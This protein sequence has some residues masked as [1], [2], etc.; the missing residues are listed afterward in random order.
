MRLGLERAP[1]RFRIRTILNQ[2]RDDVTMP[3][4]A[5]QHRPM[6][7]KPPE[8]VKR[9]HDRN[10]AAPAARG[11]DSVWRKYSA[12]YRVNNPVCRRHMELFKLAVPVGQVDHIE[13]HEG[14]EDPKFWDKKNHQPLCSVCGAIKSGLERHGERFTQDRPYPDASHGDR[15]PRGG[16]HP[17]SSRTPSLQPVG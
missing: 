13:L 7:W 11:Y 14:Q 10:R 16:G 6:G 8:V 12:R 1:G 4:R 17:N 2:D 9:A 5:R 15:A 3:K